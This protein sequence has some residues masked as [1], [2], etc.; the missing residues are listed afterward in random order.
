MTSQPIGA[1]TKRNEDSR[2]L[3]GRALFVEDL[4][5]SGMVHVAFLRSP[6]R[7]PQRER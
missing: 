2:L 3:T 1:R 7:G 5:L 4:D 6:W